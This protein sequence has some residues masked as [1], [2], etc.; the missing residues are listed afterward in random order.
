MSPAM[1]HWGTC[2]LDFQQFIFFYS[3]WIYTEYDEV[4]TQE[5]Y[6]T[7]VSLVLVRCESDVIPGTQECLRASTTMK[8][9]HNTMNPR[10]LT[11]VKNDLQ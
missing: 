3:L 4:P 5:E 2:P 1:V 11:Y 10:G 6:T 9:G 7:V 8:K